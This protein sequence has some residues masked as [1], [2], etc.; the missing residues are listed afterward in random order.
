MSHWERKLARLSERI[1][2]TNRNCNS[3]YFLL[4]GGSSPQYVDVGINKTLKT[5][6]RTLYGELQH[7][8]MTEVDIRQSSATVISPLHQYACGSPNRGEK[9]FKQTIQ[10]KNLRKEGTGTLMSIC[11]FPR[12]STCSVYLKGSPA[13]VAC[14]INGEWMTTRP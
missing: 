5:N 10:K 8:Q 14:T 6:L 3:C 11:R 7:I 2:V 4:R 13:W 1:W 9:F 12:V